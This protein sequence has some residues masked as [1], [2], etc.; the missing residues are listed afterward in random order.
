MLE[1]NTTSLTL[2]P[3]RINRIKNVKLDIE[4]VE[5]EGKAIL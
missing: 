2:T 1:L 3:L 4:Q 5:I